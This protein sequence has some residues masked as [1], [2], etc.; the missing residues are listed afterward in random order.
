MPPTPATM[1]TALPPDPDCL[2]SATAPPQAAADRPGD[3]VGPY[4]LLREL[5]AGGMATVWLAERADGVLQRQVALKL[6]HRAGVP[7]L[8]QRMARERDIL[9]ALAH[10]HIAR[11]Y[12]AGTTA[13]G[14]PWLAMELVSGVPIDQHARER[15]LAVPQRLRLFLQVAQAVA[16]AHAQL[17]VHLD[18]K[19]ANILVTPEG[20]V[21]LL[22]FGVARLLAEGPQASH[23]TRS[24]VR[25]LSLAY[26]A[27]EQVAEQPVTVATDVYALGV[28]LYEL[29][30]G[31]HPYRHDGQSQAALEEAILTAPV[32][33]ASSRMARDRA[34]ARRLRGDIDAVLDKALQ[35]DPAQRY[36]S[37]ESF[38]ADLQRHL[39]G[40][41]VL[42]QAPS[43]R[44]RA[45]KFVQRNGPLVLVSGTVALSL[46][47]GLGA[48]LWQGQAA[49]AQT[50]RAEQ[51]KGFI[52]SIFKQATPRE[53]T[54]GVVT[55]ADLLGAAAERIEAE[56]GDAPAVAAELGLI[57]GEGFSMLGEPMQ[58]EAALR[59]AVARAEQLHG[60]QHPLSLRARAFLIESINLK[61]GA[62]AER[63]AAELLPDALAGLPASAEI[64]VEVLQ[65]QSFQLAKRNQAE[66][67]YAALKEA[68]AVGERHL[69]PLHRSTITALGLLS[70]TYGRF[71]ARAEQLATATLALQRA[72]QALGAS[73]P[74]VALTA[75]ERW[76]GEALAANERPADAVPVLRRV[77]QDQRA[78]DPDG[79]PRVRTALL[80]LGVALD[81]MGR[82]AESLPLLREALA[83]EAAQNP[84]DSDDRV[85]YASRL[86]NALA[87]AQRADEALALDD[88]RAALQKKLPPV[89]DERALA[90][91][92]R[93][94]RLLAL[95]GDF[96]AAARATAAAEI[97]GDARAQLRADARLVGVFSARM[98]NR[99]AEAATLARQL[100][101]DPQ[102]DTLRLATRAAAAT[103]LGLAALELGDLPRADQALRPAGAL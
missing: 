80:Q 9:A 23:L 44:Y 69:G 21:R 33:R 47:G 86:V 48:A 32:P 30:T 57:V 84:H 29:L 60:R 25:L 46:L 12:D 50:A 34:L 18:L 81:E 76:Y 103:E 41:P 6:P 79:T 78:L 39:D 37:V 49:R 74:D 67:S 16:H 63:L 5:G 58:G 100:M 56:L 43:R 85:A 94:A 45:L 73:R 89:S 75:V 24:A 87:A 1:N 14:R 26:A 90:L 96:A 64:A 8:A 40:E 13:T 42:A 72:E 88:R 52:A 98:Q 92:V 93:R 38:A 91:D 61:D 65:E 55:A 11:L 70:N 54:G 3:D 10:P 71:R 53:G 102:M 7:G 17:V 66:P 35:K 82:Q 19:P 83:L 20:A 27:P 36:A 28:V 51:V 15:R 101:A 95:R 99:P 97:T 77:L 59:A 22:D 4:R 68:V 62:E 2:H 31:T